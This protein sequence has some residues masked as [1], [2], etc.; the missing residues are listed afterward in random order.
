M[1]RSF[2]PDEKLLFER[3]KSGDKIFL[4]RAITLIESKNEDKRALALKLLELC[5]PLSGNS[6]RVAITGAPGAGKSTLIESLGKAMI[7]Q[8]HKV[9]VLAIDPT[10]PDSLGS[11][12]GDK[13]RMSELSNSSHAFVRPS[14]SDQ[15][16]GG[17]HYSTRDSII[18]CEAAGFDVIFVETVGV[19]Q[20]EYEVDKITD[21]F[22]MVLA[23]G[24]GDEIQGLKKGILEL[25]DAMIIS[26]FDGDLMPEA[27]KTQAGLLNALK[28]RSELVQIPVLK[29]S[30]DDEN[31]GQKIINTIWEQKAKL[32]IN[33]KLRQNRESQANYW[34][35]L[36]FKIR[37]IEQLMNE[38]DVIKTLNEFEVVENKSE[39]PI[40]SIIDQKIKNWLSKKGLLNL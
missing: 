5:Q 16:L 1:S 13:T 25:A 4:A 36:N 23:P 14:P 32:L 34:F 28:F 37:L 40:S 15:I 29:Y 10:S 24:G 12:L 26:K 27:I 7:R 35:R 18:L 8:G 19:G 31:S 38:T 11:I 22:Y 33:N 3:I 9:A 39:L 21:L 2:D 20:S 17:I 30:K 6:I